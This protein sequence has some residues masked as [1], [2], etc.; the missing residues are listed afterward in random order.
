MQ[1]F[2]QYWT[3]N[4]DNYST[5]NYISVTNPPNGIVNNFHIVLLAIFFFFAVAAFNLQPGS[6]TCLPIPMHPHSPPKRK[7]YFGWEFSINFCHWN[8]PC[9]QGERQP[10]QQ[11]WWRRNPCEVATHY[12]SLTGWLPSISCVYPSPQKQWQWKFI[13]KIWYSLFGRT[14]QLQQ[15]KSNKN[16]KLNEH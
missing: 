4:R 6:Q 14:R 2:K 13:Q 1:T 12:G 8:Y 11:I 5:G 10:V 15:Q 16:C 7:K 3:L 9:G